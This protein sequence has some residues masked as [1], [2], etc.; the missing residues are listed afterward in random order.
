MCML[1]RKKERKKNSQNE[2]KKIQKKENIWILQERKEMQL[3]KQI[4]YMFSKIERK[5]IFRNERKQKP[6]LVKKES[7]NIFSREKML[8]KKIFWREK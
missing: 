8:R 2:R 6:Y 7:R 3:K 1:K 5:T 4:K